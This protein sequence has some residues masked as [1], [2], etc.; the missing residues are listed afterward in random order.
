MYRVSN[1]RYKFNR[2]LVKVRV[3]IT[4]KCRNRVL[5]YFI[6]AINNEAI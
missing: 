1:L 4:A 3:K 5:A 6:E 2:K